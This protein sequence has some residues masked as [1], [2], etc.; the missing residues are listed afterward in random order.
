MRLLFILALLF[1][2]S[3][4]FRPWRPWRPWGRPFRRGPMI[5]VRP[6]RRPW[7]RRRFW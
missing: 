7:W 3:F 2:G 4:L 6:P 1:V 5:F